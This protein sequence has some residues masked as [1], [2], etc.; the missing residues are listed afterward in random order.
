MP[1]N[2][3][4]QWIVLLFPLL[5]F[6]RASPSCVQ[7]NI[8]INGESETSLPTKTAAQCEE[9][10]SRKRCP[11]WTWE[12]GQCQLKRR[13]KEGSKVGSRG[14]VS[15]TEEA[16]RP[17]KDSTAEG[18]MCKYTDTG[19]EV[20]CLFPFTGENPGQKRGGT[21]HDT[22]LKTKKGH[23]WCAVK[24]SLSNR[25]L[26]T[27]VQ[28]RDIECGLAKNSKGSLLCPGNSTNIKATTRRPATTPRASPR[29]STSRSTTTRRTSS[30]R[31]W[32]SVVG[33][34]KS[35][36]STTR[37]PV[38]TSPTMKP[39][40]RVSDS[41]LAVFSEQLLKDDENNAAS[42]VDLK[43]GCTTRVGRKEDC[44]PRPLITLRDPGVLRKPTFSRLTE[45]YENYQPDVSV[46]EDRTREEKREEKALLDE[47]M[48]TKVMEETFDFLKANG[49][50]TKSKAEF[51]DLLSELWFS[52]YSRGKR[53]KGSSGFEHVFLGEK[54]NGAV[55]GF[56]NWLFFNHLEQMGQVNYL[57]HWEEVDLGG[58]GT[59]LSFTFRWGE[60]QK[61]FGS[62]VVGTSPE[63]E[64]ALYTTCLL[65][66]GE[67]CK[68]K[69]G[70]REVTVTTHTFTRPGGVAYIAS[71][72]ID[73]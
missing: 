18:T 61:P 8:R 40:G 53:I 48:K 45:L 54:K 32:S 11:S 15:G 19:E 29:S 20:L 16:G 2:L 6:D 56:H 33:T 60:E 12:G 71:A 73:W 50:F 4:A 1:G 43:T 31:P 38:R 28:N 37:I 35:G 27:S 70:G 52:V 9:E 21:S 49:L 13:G 25:L 68:V 58:R 46:T 57:G 39:S 26:G 64:L 62:M 3:R 65:A 10:C 44:S 23:T 72:F 14:A 51:E 63:F 17:C 66:R 47:M 34:T 59:G 36:E 24:L 30:A 69:L 67:K 7:Q 41:Q 22:C 5:F 42:L 55:Q